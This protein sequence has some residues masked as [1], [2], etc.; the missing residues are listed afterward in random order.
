VLFRSGGLFEIANAS[1]TGMEI[2]EASFVYPKE[3]KMVCEAF[4]IDPIAAIAE[5]SLLITAKPTHS[6]EII[7]RLK[8]ANI[9]ASIIGKVTGEPKTRIIKR[10]DG[11]VIPLEIPEQDPFWPVF[12]EGVEKEQNY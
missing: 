4:N 5:G 8:K 9:N 1:G 3:V 6:K 12:F 2:D 10:L 11:S 7:R